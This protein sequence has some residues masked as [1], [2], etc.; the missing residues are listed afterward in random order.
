MLRTIKR[1]VQNSKYEICRLSEYRFVGYNCSNKSLL[2]A[3][4]QCFQQ[5]LVA[6]RVL[7]SVHENVIL[8]DY[9]LL[10]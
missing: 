8:I 6:T 7:S 9:S 4:Q 10:Q 1:H 3:L 2:E 5:W